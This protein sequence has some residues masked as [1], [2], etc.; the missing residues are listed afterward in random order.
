M[1]LLFLFAPSKPDPEPDGFNLGEIGS[2]A[3]KNW[4]QATPY[5]PTG[6]RI[7]NRGNP[8]CNQNP[9]ELL[10]AINRDFGV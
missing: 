4:T 6:R 3:I 5:W 9:S 7:G 2:A 10:L 1:W 8:A